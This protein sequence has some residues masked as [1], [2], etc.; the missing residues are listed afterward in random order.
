MGAVMGGGLH[1]APSKR[2]RF[3]LEIN[4]TV[5]EYGDASVILDSV[6]VGTRI[7]KAASAT[8]IRF[9]TLFLL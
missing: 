1:L 5:I 6:Y 2:I 3:D 9:S 8:R 7:N 4:H